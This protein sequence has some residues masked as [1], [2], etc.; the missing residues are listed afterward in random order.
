MVR[1]GGASADHGRPPDPSAPLD[2]DEGLRAE[3]AA[4]HRAAVDAVENAALARPDDGRIASW[5]AAMHAHAVDEAEGKLSADALDRLLAA[6]EVLPSFNLFTALIMFRDQP[7]DSPQSAALFARV[8]RYLADLPCRDVRPDTPEGRIC[9][10]GPRA[11]HNNVTA[12]V[13]IA[14]VYLRRGEA[15]F[16]A[17]DFARAM[18]LVFTAKGIYATAFDPERRDETRAWRNGPLVQARL[19]RVASLWPGQPPPASDFW[20]STDYER[21]YECSSCHVQ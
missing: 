19:E 10:N 7:I 6:V 14:D 17:R 8:E 12:R 21:I 13:M 4:R 9:L 1:V 5:R 20:R 3:R 16:A 18:P 11:P 15:A 2:R